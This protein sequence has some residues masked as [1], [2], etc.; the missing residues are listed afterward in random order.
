MSESQ[1]P[2]TPEAENLGEI[3]E[4]VDK[5]SYCKNG[6]VNAYLHPKG[7]IEGV[8]YYGDWDEMA[9]LVDAEPGEVEGSIHGYMSRRVSS[10]VMACLMEINPQVPTS[11]QLIM[12]ALETKEGQE[13]VSAYMEKF[14]LEAIDRI[15]FYMSCGQF[16]GPNAVRAEQIS[17]KIIAA[18]DALMKLIKEQDWGKYV[19]GLDAH[20][21]VNNLWNY[22]N[23]KIR[24]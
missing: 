1:K 14:A 3:G 2:A 20:Y 24:K 13:L 4:M 8:R 18:T 21:L 9:R 11:E 23:M 15:A 10:Q 22:A 17:N 5:I 6:I 19:V 16:Y 7:S 12:W